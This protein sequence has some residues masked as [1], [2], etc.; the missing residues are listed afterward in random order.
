MS[1]KPRLQF[2][3]IVAKS[4]S[5]RDESLLLIQEVGHRIQLD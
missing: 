3:E 5:S 2:Y 4:S 1:L